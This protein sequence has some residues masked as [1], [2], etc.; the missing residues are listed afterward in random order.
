VAQFADFPPEE[1]PV[2]V[3]DTDAAATTMGRPAL[4]A[5]FRSLAGPFTC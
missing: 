1:Q 3:N 5:R 4:H 2:Q